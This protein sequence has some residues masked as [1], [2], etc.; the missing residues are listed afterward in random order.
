ME[1]SV[2]R[3]S[4]SLRVATP[5]NELAPR[6]HYDPTLEAGE[7]PFAARFGGLDDPGWL[8]VLVRSLEV[9]IIEG[10]EFPGFPESELQSII[11]GITGVSSLQEAHRFYVFCRDHTYDASESVRDLRFLDFG[12]GWG[13]ITRPFLRDFPLAGLY[14]YEPNFLFCTIARTLNPY[15]CFIHGKKKPGAWLPPAWFDVVVGWS[16]FSHLGEGSARGWLGEIN[17]AMRPGGWCVMTTWG[18]RFL[19]RLVGEKRKLAS[20][21]DI[22]WYSEL[23]V[24][25][26]GDIRARKAEYD[27]G[28]FVF[29]GQGDPSY[30]EAIISEA[31]LRRIL[32]EEQLD[33][34][35]THFDTTSLPQDAFVLRR[36]G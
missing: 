20:G 26:A 15:S 27:R 10:L 16:I 9:R 23:C 5:L 18:A 30:G 35:L 19:D 3:D 21:E 4:D 8:D 17:R 6:H 12:A 33:F 11:H 2:E 22:H 32:R 29:F 36:P 7:N 31:A 1:S 24:R 14:G 34:E 28:E 13:R 25:T